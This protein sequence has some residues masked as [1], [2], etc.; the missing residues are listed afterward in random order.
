M[1]HAFL[2][3]RAGARVKNGGAPAEEHGAEHI[4]AAQQEPLERATARDR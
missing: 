2:P 1:L 3:G 4:W